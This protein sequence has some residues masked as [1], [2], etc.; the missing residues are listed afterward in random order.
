MKLWLIVPVKPFNEG[1]SRLSRALQPA[2]RAELSARLLAQT[3]ST[4]QHSARFDQIVVVS[5]DPA[6][7]AAARTAAAL[8]L[9]EAG[10]ELNPALAQACAYAG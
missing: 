6:V 8:G 7:L 1:K 10:T 3:L 9:P 5:R 2:Q 4:A